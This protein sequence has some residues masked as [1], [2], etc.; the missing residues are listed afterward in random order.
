MNKV[1]RLKLFLQFEECLRERESFTKIL[2]LKKKKQ[3][4]VCIY[5]KLKNK[6]TELKWKRIS[7]FVKAKKCT[8]EANV[9]LDTAENANP[10]LIFQAT[11][12]LNE[13]AKHIW[14]QTNLYA[15]QNG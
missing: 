15:T 10:L 8:L 14:D 7:K 6:V 13:L 4:N 1:K 5:I 9:L 2:L 3:Q 11:T 12:H